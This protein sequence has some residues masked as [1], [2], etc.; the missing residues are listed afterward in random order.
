MEWIYNP[1]LIA[2]LVVYLVRTCSGYY[3][4]CENV[5]INTLKIFSPAES[6]GSYVACIGKLAVEYKCFSNSV[7]S[8]GSESCLVCDENGENLIG[9]RK[10]TDLSSEANENELFGDDSRMLAQY[11]AIYHP[12]YNLETELSTESDSQNSSSTASDSVGELMEVGKESEPEETS[13]KFDEEPMEKSSVYKNV[14]EFSGE[15]FSEQSSNEIKYEGTEPSEH[16]ES[17]EDF[18][19]S[20]QNEN[21]DKSSDNS[22]NREGNESA[23]TSSNDTSSGLFVFVL[24]GA[25]LLG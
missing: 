1:I 19:S 12:Q 25:F 10:S 2:L 24:F 18:S 3:R 14:N 23:E 7:Y 13:S 6:C 11:E 8:D 9:T 5:P 20:S 16:F 4:S 21:L 15:N 17:A 22:I